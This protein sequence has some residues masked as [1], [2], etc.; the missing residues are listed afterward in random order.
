MALQLNPDLTEA[1]ASLAYVHMMFDWDWEASER[2]FQC[3]RSLNRAYS[4]ARYWYSIWL[5]IVGRLDES[6][7]EARRALKCDLLSAYA[8]T[9]LGIMLLFCGRVEE[10]QERYIGSS[11]ILRLRWSAETRNGCAAR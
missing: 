5:L 4:P 8:Q 6:I 3:A 1:H 9:H 10:E 7:A 2:E 11:Y